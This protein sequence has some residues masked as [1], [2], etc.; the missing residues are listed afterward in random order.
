MSVDIERDLLVLPL[1]EAP[2]QIEMR[3]SSF[4]IDR[5]SSLEPQIDE[6]VRIE[7]SVTEGDCIFYEGFD[8]LSDRLYRW[9]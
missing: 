8:E 6:S 9:D 1:R 4:C 7:T 2:Q 3:L 5:Q